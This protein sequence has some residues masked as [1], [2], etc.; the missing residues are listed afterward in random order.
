MLSI[1]H[2]ISEHWEK[3]MGSL[4]FPGKFFSPELEY[5]RP[6]QCANARDSSTTLLTLYVFLMI[7]YFCYYEFTEEIQNL[8]CQDAGLYCSEI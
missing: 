7:K 1:G 4:A 2:K 3:K 5:Q 6:G 8:I